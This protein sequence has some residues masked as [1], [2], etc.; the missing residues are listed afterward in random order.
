MIRLTKED[1]RMSERLEQARRYHAAI[2]EVLMGEWDPIG[3]ANIPE[4]ADEYDSYIGEVH[5]LLVRRE[6]LSK[7]VDFLR[8][9]ETEHMGLAGNRCRTEQVAARLLRLPEELA[10]D[11][12]PGAASDR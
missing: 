8:W 5:G 9:V 10:S 1:A 12:E 7:M 3:V 4:A 6:P 11:T 2:R